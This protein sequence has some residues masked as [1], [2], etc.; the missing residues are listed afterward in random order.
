MGW[1]VGQNRIRGCEGQQ[2]GLILCRGMPGKFY[3]QGPAWAGLPFGGDCLVCGEKGGG[4]V[5]GVN[6]HELASMCRVLWLAKGTWTLPL[7]NLLSPGK[8]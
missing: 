3:K 8:R 7:G 5:I 1:A 4:G 6:C 2:E